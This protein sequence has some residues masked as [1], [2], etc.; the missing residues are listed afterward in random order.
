MNARTTLAF[1]LPFMVAT[2]LV[3]A[4]GCGWTLKEYSNPNDD[5]TLAKC[6]ALGRAAK[7]DGSTPDQAWNIYDLCV[8]DAGLR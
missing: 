7:A 5:T 4:S 8:R 3:Q 1:T 6:R 2:V